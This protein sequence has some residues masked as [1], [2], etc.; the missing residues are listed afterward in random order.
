M[1]GKKDTVRAVV[2]LAGEFV[3]KR[4]GE[5]DHESWESFLK[6]AAKAG[7]DSSEDSQRALGRLLEGIKGIYNAIQEPVPVKKRRAE[8]TEKAP[9]AE[10]P[11]KVEKA[12][13]P[14]K[15]PKASKPSPTE[16]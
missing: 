7:I 4:K 15:A 16:D 10:K 3:I 12:P 8:K 9:K 6:K 2:E 14:A 5:W 13:K 11:V 1:A